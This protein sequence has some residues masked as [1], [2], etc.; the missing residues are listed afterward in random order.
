MSIT[1]IE[2]ELLRGKIRE[3][4]GENMRAAATDESVA[5]HS[6]GDDPW[7]AI[8]AQ[9]P[10]HAVITRDKVPIAADFSGEPDVRPSAVEAPSITADHF[11]PRAPKS[12]DEAGLTHSEIEALVLKFLLARGPMAG[13]RIA[14]QVR[15]PFPVVVQCLRPLKEER[16]LVYKGATPL[17]DYVYELTEIGRERASRYAER[18]TYFGSAP[19]TIE[20]YVASV[21]TQLADRRKPKLADLRRA[22]GGLVLSDESLAQLGQAMSSGSGLFLYGAPGNGKTSIAERIT[23]AYGGTVWIPRAIS[24]SGDIIRIFDPNIHRPAPLDPAT[25]DVDGDAIDR[26]WVRIYRPTI[27]A[28]GE[29]TMASL[30]INTIAATGISEAALQIKSNLGTLV[31]DDFG[32]QRVSPSELLNRWIVPLARQHDYFTL[33]SGRKI[34]LPFA[35]MLVFSTNL[36]PSDLVDEA[37]LRRI[38]YKI[39]ISDPSEEEFREIMLRAAA[40]MGLRC[41]DEVVDYCIEHHFKA[42]GRPM[43]RCHPRDLLSQGQD[44]CAFHDLPPALTR[45]ALDVAVKNYFALI[46]LPVTG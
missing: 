7:W 41:D 22:F 28:G 35:Q 27:V 5:P 45:E 44:F 37:F 40:E 26:R 39:D 23:A 21:A 32:R 10:T 42:S 8:A 19:V 14:A 6:D 11:V 3:I 36:D 15:L 9:H 33:A 4:L 1:E 31:I 46:H 16:V 34:Q 20:E 25:E 12:L 18:C 43:R 30:E 2:A 38:P 17:G 24:A 29:L 13:N